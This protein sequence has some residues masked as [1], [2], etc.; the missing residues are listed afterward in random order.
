MPDISINIP[1]TVAAV[2]TDRIKAWLDAQPAVM[3]DSGADEPNGDPIMI[4]MP[5]TYQEKFLR[6][7]TK[8]IKYELQKR[9]LNF[10]KRTTAAAV[11][12]LPL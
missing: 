6:L 3:I 8:F 4:P 5:E 1:L 12:E 2:H 10:E 9:I 7:S 11:Q